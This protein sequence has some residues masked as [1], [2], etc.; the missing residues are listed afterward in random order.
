MWF[1]LAA[2]GFM[3]LGRQLGW[4]VSRAL[5]YPAPIPLS[6]V[7]AVVWGIVVGVGMSSLIGWLHPGTIL[8]W[9]LGF[10]L[11]AYV[12][13]PN[14]GLFSEDTIP[15]SDRPRHLM[16]SNVPLIA[17]LVTE[18]TTQSLR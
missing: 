13:I 10:A 4:G 18:F 9:I 8:K 3:F 2:I 15:D 12:A 17:Y 11:G 5:L 14:Y 7:G 6:V 1:A 16:I